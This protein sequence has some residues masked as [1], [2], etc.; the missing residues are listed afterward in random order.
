LSKDKETKLTP[1]KKMNMSDKLKIV[2][3]DNIQL[4]LNRI[5]FSIMDNGINSYSDNHNHNS[6]NHNHNPN[7][8]NSPV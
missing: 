5:S 4:S 1:E 7:Y 2:I 3:I 6:S 8:I